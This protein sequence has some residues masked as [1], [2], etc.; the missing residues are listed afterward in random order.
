MATVV[1]LHFLLSV[2]HILTIAPLF[3][4]VAFQRARTP[5]WIYAVFLALG[6]LLLAYHGWKF[7][8]RWEARSSRTWINLFH[9]VMV[10]PLLLYIGYYRDSTPRAAYELLMILS[11]GLVGYHIFNLVRLLEAHP[12]E[13]E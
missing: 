13:T 11:W 9:V 12:Y 8:V 4:F 5:S 3:L 1:D 7:M 6:A 2:F 10:A